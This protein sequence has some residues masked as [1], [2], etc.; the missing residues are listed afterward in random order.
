ML[1]LEIQRRREKDFGIDASSSASSASASWTDKGQENEYEC[2]SLCT[3]SESIE[4]VKHSEECCYES[5]SVA[6]QVT[7]NELAEQDE[8]SQRETGYDML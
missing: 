4:D 7:A 5:E 2:D 8:E 6:S 3:E 1:L